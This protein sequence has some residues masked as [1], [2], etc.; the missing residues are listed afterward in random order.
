MAA[1]PGSILLGIILPWAAT[2]IR[3]GDLL[4]HLV[5]NGG[6]RPSMPPSQDWWVMIHYVLT[7]RSVSFLVV[8]NFL[9]Q[10]NRPH[11]WN[12][13]ASNSVIRWM[14]LRKP[15]AWSFA[16]AGS[17]NHICESLMCRVPLYPAHRRKFYVI[18]LDENNIDASYDLNVCLNS[19]NY[20]K[21]QLILMYYLDLPI[22]SS[23]IPIQ[24]GWIWRQRHQRSLRK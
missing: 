20:F 7:I 8:Y 4:I 18:M 12:I 3:S 14:K 19:Q 15:I 2:K 23:Y 11:G 6:R 9:V 16:I 10:K 13:R 24:Y 1:S 21:S 22:G 5:I 17:N